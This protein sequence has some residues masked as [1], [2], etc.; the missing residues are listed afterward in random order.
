M[1][2]RTRFRNALA[3]LVFAGLSLVSAAQA[4]AGRIATPYVPKH[5]YSETASPTAD[6]AAAL[7]Q[8]RHEQKRVLLDCGGDWCGDCQVL[9]IYFHQQPNLRLL[10]DHFVL[11]HVWIGHQDHNLDIAAKYGAQP[12][13]GVPT[14]AV[15]GPSGNVL[16]T[17][18]PHEFSSMRYMESSSVTDFLNRWKN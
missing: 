15:L 16:Y 10:E 5:L 9:D 1:V 6:I 8:A 11:V 18:D 17:Q 14:L 2:S 3:L 12:E 7:K 13:H 4:Q